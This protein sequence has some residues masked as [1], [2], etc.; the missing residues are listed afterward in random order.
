MTYHTGVTGKTACRE[1]ANEKGRPFG[2][3]S[4]S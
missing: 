3:P 4:H 1:K 2:R